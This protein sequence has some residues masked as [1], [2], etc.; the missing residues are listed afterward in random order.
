MLAPPG[1]RGPALGIFSS[2]RYAVSVHAIEPRDVLFAFTDGIFEVANSGEDLFGRTRPREA[3]ERHL[4]LEPR[5]LLG[6]VVEEVQKFAVGRRFMDDVCV[7][8]VEVGPRMKGGAG[9]K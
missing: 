2:A 9:Q 7:V 4:D 5:E 8:G 1:V 6:A 3:F